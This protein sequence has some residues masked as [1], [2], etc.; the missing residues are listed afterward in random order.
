MKLLLPRL[1][2]PDPYRRPLSYLGPPTNDW[3]MV[4]VRGGCLICDR[5]E[6]L[7]VAFRNTFYPNIS[8]RGVGPRVVLR[9]VG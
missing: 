1:R 3:D 8:G 5:S 4:I 9:R 2:T 6:V 7:A